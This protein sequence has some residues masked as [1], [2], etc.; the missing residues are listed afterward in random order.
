MLSGGNFRRSSGIFVVVVR[1]RT[2][3]PSI[4]GALTPRPSADLQG[5]TATLCASTARTPPHPR[6]QFLQMLVLP[7]CGL[8]W[9]LAQ[10]IGPFRPKRLIPAAFSSGTRGLEDLGE[11]LAL[12]SGLGHRTHP[13]H[14]FLLSDFGNSLGPRPRVRRQR[15]SPARAGL[16]LTSMA[17]AHVS[18][19]KFSGVFRISSGDLACL[20]TQQDG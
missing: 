2:P 6:R 9:E 12:L 1:I 17:M 19:L 4:H 11:L 7:S 14:S 8:V 13:P 20:A 18:L 10:S 5:P 15:S 3:Q 16:P